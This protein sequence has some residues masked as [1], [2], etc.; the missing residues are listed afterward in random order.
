MIYWYWW[1]IVKDEQ[2]TIS[3]GS[4]NLLHILH[5]QITKQNNMES[6]ASDLKNSIVVGSWV[7]TQKPMA[8]DKYLFNVCEYSWSEYEYKYKY[9]AVKYEY[10]YEYIASKYKYLKCVLEYYLSTSTSTK[11]YNS[12]KK[13][14]KYLYSNFYYFLCPR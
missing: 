14:T 1:P 9:W 5:R 8:Q 13:P 7:E 10:K 6:I 2:R 3:A 11:Y 12:G 4:V